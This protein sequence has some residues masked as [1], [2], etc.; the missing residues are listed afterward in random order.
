MSVKFFPAI[1]D[2][3]IV[4]PLLAC[5][6]DAIAGPEILAARRCPACVAS[7]A[8]PNRDVMDLFDYLGLERSLHGDIPAP[9]LRSLCESR[10][11]RVPHT[12]YIRERCRDLLVLAV[13]C[14]HNSIA[15]R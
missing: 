10:L 3:N 1:V 12:E 4:V 14:A 5:A 11:E 13:A 7:L 2:G 15:W 6:C 9:V 8:L